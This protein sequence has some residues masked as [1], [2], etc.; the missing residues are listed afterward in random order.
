MKKKRGSAASHNISE[1]SKDGSTG[2]KEKQNRTNSVIR[3]E[4][5][6]GEGKR[7]VLLECGRGKESI[8]S[9]LLAAP[10]G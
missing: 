6:R 7:E 3:Y 2:E 4:S 9:S 10:P 8:L 1:E 5:R